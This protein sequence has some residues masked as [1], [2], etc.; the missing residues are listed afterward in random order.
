MGAFYTSTLI[1]RPSSLVELLTLLPR[2]LRDQFSKRGPRLAKLDQSFPPELLRSNRIG[3]LQGPFAYAI[4]RRAAR[5]LR[6][7]APDSAPVFDL[8]R[9]ALIVD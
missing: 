7:L 6:D 5:R 3:I 1:R 2:A 4:A 9:G 8:V